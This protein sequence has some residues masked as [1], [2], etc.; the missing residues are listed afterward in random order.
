MST[1]VLSEHPMTVAGTRQLVP[2]LLGAAFLAVILTSLAGGL[3]I[4]TALGSGD[5][6]DL[7]AHLSSRLTMAR[8]GVLMDLATSV[9]IVSLAALLYTVLRDHGRVVARIALGCWLLEAMFMATSRLGALA[10]ARL[11]EG[12]VDAGSP[13]QSAYQVVGESLYRGLYTQGYTI[14]MFFYCVGGLLWYGLFYRS[15]T[16]PDAISLLG[17]A[18]AAVGLVGI[19]VEVFGAS[20]PTLVFLPLLG[21][22]LAIGVWLILRGVSEVDQPK[23]T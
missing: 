15:H 5:D 21:F 9:G 2:R 7:L 13:A 3:L 23:G 17:I 19:T 22:E 12:F 20:V 16:V 11:S 6:A 1:L 8:A 4:D 10:L 18:A 14:H